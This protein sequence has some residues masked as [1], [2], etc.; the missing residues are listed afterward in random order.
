MRSNAEPGVAAVAAGATEAL[1]RA[2][3]AHFTNAQLQANS[4]NSLR[5]LLRLRAAAVERI[6]AAGAVAAGL[7]ALRQHSLNAKVQEAGWYFLAQLCA[8]DEACGAVSTFELAAAALHAHAMHNG[9]QE[10]ACHALVKLTTNHADNQR[11]ALVAGV[12]DALVALLRRVT[13]AT[14]SALLVKALLALGSGTSNCAEAWLHAVRLGAVEAIIAV[15]RAHGGDISVQGVGCLALSSLV[16]KNGSN[17]A[18]ALRAGAM[19]VTQAALR[20]LGDAAADAKMQHVRR[21][22]VVLQQGEAAG[23][24]ADDAAMAALVAQEQAERAAKPAAALKAKSKSGKKKKK[25]KGGD[26]GGGSGSGN[27]EGTESGVAAL[28]EADG[29]PAAAAAAATPVAG[30]AAG[31]EAAAATAASNSDALLRGAA[32][33]AASAL[34]HDG[35]AAAARGTDGTGGDVTAALRAGSTPSDQQGGAASGACARSAHTCGGCTHTCHLHAADP[36]RAALCAASERCG[37]SRA[38]GGRRARAHGSAG[39]RTRAR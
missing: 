28:P 29:A 37:R 13:S 22:L 9:L 24:A 25:G 11:R 12:L 4:L 17:M 8:Q 7:A 15:L 39:A 20:T 14:P 38:R 19:T 10:G 36:P 33:A 26:G 30:S 3:H 1:V 32:A 21:L 23:A 31:G 18:A 16:Q 2:Q 27:G 5:C 35:T 6:R 34:R